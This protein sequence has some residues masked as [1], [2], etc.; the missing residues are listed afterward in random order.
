N[1]LT[2]IYGETVTFAGTEFRT[3][4][5]QLVNGDTVSRVTLASAGAPATAPVA[6]SP[7]AI[8]ASAAVGTGLGNYTIS[9]APGQL[10]V[11]SFSTA[12]TNLQ[13]MVDTAHL[14]RG[15]QSSLDTQLQ[16]AFALFNQGDTADGVSQ[17]GAFINHVGALR[18][19]QIPADLADALIA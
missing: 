3:G 13:A 12:T 10:T 14:A 6:G 15:I 18:G 9:Y 8:T 7:Y 1:S 5:G 16:A 19:S 11:I 4:A 2:K 17:L